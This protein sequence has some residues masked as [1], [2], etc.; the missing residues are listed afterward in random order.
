MRLN[1]RV[2][3]LRDIYEVVTLHPIV[4]TTVTYVVISPII[5]QYDGSGV[6]SQTRFSIFEMH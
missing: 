3:N 2:R 6:D 5:P 1:E 4:P